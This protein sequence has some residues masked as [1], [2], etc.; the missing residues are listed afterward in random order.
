MTQMASL[1][2]ELE[3][4]VTKILALQ[5]ELSEKEGQLSTEQAE[6]AEAKQVGLATQDTLLTTQKHL[7]EKDTQLQVCALYRDY[8]E[9]MLSTE[10][11]VD[12]HVLICKIL[13]RASL[14]SPS[15]NRR[16]RPS[17]KQHKVS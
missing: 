10:I 12:A 5:T 15:Q 2:S 3:K 6:L 7:A 11:I 9:N 8:L 16:S 1:Q 17:C 13:R 14:K 4:K